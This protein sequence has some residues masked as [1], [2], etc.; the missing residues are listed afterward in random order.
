[1]AKKPPIG[2]L[3]YVT[4]AIIINSRTLVN[5]I[6]LLGKSYLTGP[7]NGGLGSHSISYCC[8]LI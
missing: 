8:F 2:N 4:N 3:E 1:M 7:K 5:T 6:E